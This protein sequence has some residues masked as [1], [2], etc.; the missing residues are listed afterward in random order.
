MGVIQ[1]RVAA[2]LSFKYPLTQGKRESVVRQPPTVAVEESLRPSFPKAPK[3]PPDLARADS[4]TD[5]GFLLGQM[6]VLYQDDDLQPAEFLLAHSDSL[7]MKDRIA[8][9]RRV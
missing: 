7:S 8:R 9:L 4:K 5:S 3:Q 1:V 2:F 6:S